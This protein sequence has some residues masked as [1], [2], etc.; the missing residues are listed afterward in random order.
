M[1]KI[2]GFKIDVLEDLSLPS[3]TGRGQNGLLDFIP[4]RIFLGIAGRHYQTFQRHQLDWD[5]F[6]SGKVRFLDARLNDE[7]HEAVCIPMP[8]SIHTPKKQDLKTWTRE[9]LSQKQAFNFAKIPLDQRS[10]QHTGTQVSLFE[11][12]LSVYGNFA[13]FQQNYALKTAIDHKSGTS[14]DGKLFGISS[15]KA[16]VS[17]SL[18][19]EVD[20][21]EHQALLIDLIKEC[22]L[23]N[24]GLHRIGQS[25]TAEYGA[26]QIQSSNSQ[27][28]EYNLTWQ[29]IP[30]Y[31]NSCVEMNR[32]TDPTMLVY[33]FKKKTYIGCDQQNHLFKHPSRP[34][35]YLLSFL[36]LSDTA[37][38][39]AQT[40]Q[41]TMKPKAEDFGLSAGFEFDIE[42]S[43]IRKVSWHLYHG[44]Y[45]RPDLERHAFKAGSVISFAI[46]QKALA[47]NGLAREIDQ[48]LNQIWKGVGSHRSEGLGQVVLQHELLQFEQLKDQDVYSLF[49]SLKYPKTASLS[50]ATT[51]VK[52]PSGQFASWLNAKQLDLELKQRLQRLV[53]LV[54][55]YE[56]KRFCKNGPGASQWGMIAEIAQ[57]YCYKEM[58]YQL[59][60][61]HLIGDPQTLSSS[62]TED[63]KPL[64]IRGVSKKVWD[65]V[66]TYQVSSIIF[67][68]S[69]KP[70]YAIAFILQPEYI[71][72]L[73]GNH[74]YQEEFAK[75]ILALQQ[76]MKTENQSGTKNNQPDHQKQVERFQLNTFIPMFLSLLAKQMADHI[77]FNGVQR[78][79]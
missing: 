3:G 29:K 66:G 1:T 21:H 60:K 79:S 40:A 2:L 6:F 67:E 25:R 59:L 50:A 75:V 44:K 54:F 27:A 55:E 57:S 73:K 74:V 10:P 7:S 64:L 31:L 16:G 26:I 13:K 52:M 43:F 49:P 48:A 11:R 9:E 46:D 69:T 41:P 35:H 30:T 12:T 19:I 8:L 58:G 42:Y 4:G 32:I 18:N 39:D 17:F 14:S 70:G 37:L 71:D 24:Q 36:L 38:I 72:Y 68:K 22:F 47:V 56:F 63:K 34:N 76:G 53:N 45:Q 5:V 62:L 78:K 77:K 15:I 65:L 23:G 51:V 33:E 61:N 28:F 20:D